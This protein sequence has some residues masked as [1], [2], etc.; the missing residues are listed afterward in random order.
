M[1]HLL[2]HLQRA[3]YLLFDDTYIQ[4][5]FYLSFINNHFTL[6]SLCPSSHP[7]SSIILSPFILPLSI[8]ISLFLSFSVLFLMSTSP[9]FIHHHHPLHHL[10]SPTTLK[11]DLSY[12]DKTYY[13]STNNNSNNNSTHPA[14]SI[15]HHNNNNGNSS[16]SS[17]D[18]DS[19]IMMTN[20]KTQL[21]ITRMH[22]LVFN[23]A[24]GMISTV[25]RLDL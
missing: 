6:T 14:S 22:D 20:E 25:S 10:F 18:D 13:P 23:R 1:N 17:N 21:S 5:C 19:K 8:S 16:N 4:P 11:H 15:S 9:S 3:G 7:S 24:L 2:V 12:V